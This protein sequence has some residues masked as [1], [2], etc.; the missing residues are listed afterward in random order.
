[1]RMEEEIEGGGCEANSRPCI[2]CLQ[3]GIYGAVCLNTTEY[4]GGSAA[5]PPH[6]IAS[7]IINISAEGYFHLFCPC[8]IN[9]SGHIYMLY[10]NA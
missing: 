3:C 9:T 2:V 1:M 6:K 5:Q 8:K 4:V 10:K 7:Q